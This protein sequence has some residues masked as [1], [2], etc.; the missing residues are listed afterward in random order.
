MITCLSCPNTPKQRRVDSA[1]IVEYTVGMK[2]VQY[3]IRAVPPKVDQALRQRARKT[4]KSLN[5]VVIETLEKGA[6]VA[7]H[8]SFDDLD[9]FIGTGKTSKT[10]Q[11]AQGWLDA[12]P[13]ELP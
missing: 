9:W 8:E 4:G 13:M 3:T 2:S 6:G 11:A 5:D 1:G 7:R 10:E 12:A